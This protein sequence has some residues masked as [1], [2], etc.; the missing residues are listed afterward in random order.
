MNLAIEILVPIIT[1]IVIVFLSR[2]FLP[3]RVSNRYAAAIAFAAAFFIG[4]V[5]LPSW[6]EPP[7]NRHW[8][9]LPYLVAGAMVIGPLG[10]ASGIL[11][12]E[13]WLMKPSPK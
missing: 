13:R 5:L 12:A 4:Y 7:P 3:D 10:L 6:A 8:H 1:S 11:A 2:R 9:W